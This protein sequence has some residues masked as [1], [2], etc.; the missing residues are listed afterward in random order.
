GSRSSESVVVGQARTGRLSR[1]SPR[2]AGMTDFVKL[3]LD[4][5][6]DGAVA[7]IRIDKAPVNALNS[8]VQDELRQIADE[9]GRRDSIRAVILWGGPKVF[10]AGADVK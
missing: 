3:E 4:E 6:T 8:Q 1:L 5:A 7:T 10:V 2:L 9:C